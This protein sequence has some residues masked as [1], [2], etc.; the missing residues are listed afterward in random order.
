MYL[1]LSMQIELTNHCNFKCV[2]CP[3]AIYGDDAGP[4]GNPFNRPKGYISQEL[5]IKA[6][7]AANRHARALTI[8]FFGEQ[9]L[10]K[11]FDQFILYIPPRKQRGYQTFLNTNF[12]LV[13]EAHVELLRRF[14]VVRI[15]LDSS[16][17]NRWEALCPGG[18]VLQSNGK[19]GEGSRFDVLAEKI[20]WW[21]ALPERATTNLIFVTQQSNKA[22]AEQFVKDWR[23]TL[24]GRDR[25]NVKSILTY[26]GV[27]ADP[28]MQANPCAVDILKSFTVAWDGRC[29]PCNL[30]VNLAMAVMNLNTNTA[31]EIVASDAWAA[32]LQDINKHRGMC[33]NCF[34]AQNHS[35][36]F[37]GPV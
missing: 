12:A 16:D 31:E 18:A 2:Y 1:G 24:R 6:M 25:I 37:T 10:H 9:L 36:R 3:H 26:G 23:P 17:P 27:M 30:D 20:R 15:S 7:D 28:Y 13:T 21:M 19:K 5:W 29:T 4:S 11:R 8:G 32:K 35:Q 14:D 22:E 34:D 33:A